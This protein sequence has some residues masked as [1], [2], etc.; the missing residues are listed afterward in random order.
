MSGNSLSARK[1]HPPLLFH[2][3]KMSMVG[4]G[5]LFGCPV[6]CVYLVVTVP[7]NLSVV[8]ARADPMGFTRSGR[9]RSVYFRRARATIRPDGSHWVGAIATRQ[10]VAEMS[11]DKRFSA[12]A[13][14]GK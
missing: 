5:D 14:A 11:L 9:I 2:E 7:P 13:S 10:V 12:A 4:A 3:E 1:S 8:R 6:R